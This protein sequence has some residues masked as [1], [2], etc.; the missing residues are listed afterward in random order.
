MRLTPED[1]R[2]L[3]EKLIYSRRVIARALEE[4]ARPVVLYTGGK[5][6][7]VLLWLVRQVSP[8]IP[9]LL[10]DHGL[11]FPETWE[12]LEE[13]KAEWDLKLMVVC[14]EDV[15]AH[16]KEPGAL[17]SISSLSDENRREVREVLAYM[18]ESFPYTLDTEV[19]NH[20]LKTV[21]LKR[22]IRSHGFDYVFVGIRWDEHPARSRER[23]F[24]PRE[25]PP[26][27]RVHPIL[28]L[29]ERDIWQVMLDEGLPI[30]PLYAQGYRSLDS[31]EAQK[32]DG[33]PAWEQE[34]G[35]GERAGREQD[36]EGV[37]ERLRAL[38]YM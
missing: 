23:F 34:L 9:A 33:R 5:D 31:I 35:V 27:M 13:L 22:A 7:T 26:H 18:E 16:A 1:E 19:G 2:P 20:L 6:S 10:I 14:N 11:H 24:S 30:H 15:L 4:A 3:G 8:K 38:G 17:I 36:K 32:T 21:P 25:E 37:M 29:S 28:H 12:F